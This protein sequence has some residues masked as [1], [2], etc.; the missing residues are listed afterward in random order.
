MLTANDF[1]LIRS[2]LSLMGC[3]YDNLPLA[4]SYYLLCQYLCHDYNVESNTIREALS[5][6]EIDVFQQKLHFSKVFTS[7]DFS[8]LLAFY[9]ILSQLKL[10]INPIAFYDFLWPYLVHDK[11]RFSRLCSNDP[12]RQSIAL[13][14]IILISLQYDTTSIP[15]ELEFEDFTTWYDSIHSFFPDYSSSEELASLFENLWRTCFFT[16]MS[17]PVIASVK[18]RRAIK[19]FLDHC[20]NTGISPEAYLSDY[21][22]IRNEAPGFKNFTVHLSAA[23]DDPHFESYD[24][25]TVQLLVGLRSEPPTFLLHFLHYTDSAGRNLDD[26]EFESSFFVNELM[27]LQ[28]SFTSLLIL[29]PSPSFIRDFCSKGTLRN[30]ATF[31]IDDDLA[32]SLLRTEFPDTLFCTLHQLLEKPQLFDA[33]A[34]FTHL[35]HE[36]PF[37]GIYHMLKE[38][39][40][41]LALI[42][43]TH[44]THKKYIRTLYEHNVHINRLVAIPGDLTRTVPKKKALVYAKKRSN[45]AVPPPVQLFFA[46][47]FPG[48]L[49]YIP[50]AGITFDASVLFQGRTLIQLNNEFARNIHSEKGKIGRASSVYPFSKE[51]RIHYTLMPNRAD[52]YSAQVC[53]RAILNK[54]GK[55]STRGKAL[56][57]RTEKGFRFNTEAEVMSAIEAYPLRSDV[58]H[59]ITMDLWRTH[60]FCKTPYTLKT[61]WYRCLGYLDKD[62]NYKHSVAVSLFCSPNNEAVS[63]LILDQCTDETFQNTL[64]ECTREQLSQ[65]DLI[66]AVAGKNHLIKVNP[67]EKIQTIVDKI[68]E[69]KPALSTVL[70][71]LGKG[72]FT[73]EEESRIVS[74]LLQTDADKGVPRCVVNSQY[75]GVA[76]RLCTG[77]S[78]RE[79]AALQW[80]NIVA[81]DEPD[82]WQFLVMQ[83]INDE[84]KPITNAF[85]NTKRAHRKIPCPEFLRQLLSLRKTYL[86]K[87]FRLSEKRIQNHPIILKDEYPASGLKGF[88]PQ[89]CTARK[90]SAPCKQSLTAAMIPANIINLTERDATF[91]IDLNASLG[92]IFRFNFRLRAK[93]ICA[94]TSGELCYISGIKAKRTY[95][96]HYADYSSTLSQ[97]SIY[98]A[99]NEWTDR[100]LP[101]V[102]VDTP[103][104]YSTVIQA[105]SAD[106]DIYLRLTNMYAMSCFGSFLPEQEEL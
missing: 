7:E 47:S 10:D 29:C 6:R 91:E 18:N 42:P 106:T 55:K 92:D 83:H 82:F 31:L 46:K 8:E 105:T 86:L 67:R 20:K 98:F 30:H 26:F 85:Y 33:V 53:Y 57:S 38:D 89:F 25:K 104:I 28:D 64:S 84:G 54:D 90:L 71:R 43:Q 102:N 50:N 75:L 1:S 24:K 35:A 88:T 95:D 32:C 73:W 87:T 70:S 103:N 16:K 62:I 78:V 39:A 15:N 2:Q 5:S 4:S 68:D 34:V 27:S 65:I 77:M 93:H 41:I 72:A 74:Y 3:D 13:H 21:H 37:D 56:T 48:K 36:L 17:S 51:I 45:T 79:I 61:V 99:L 66:L 19:N 69:K 81:K 97:A 100:Y 94:L 96:E 11:S 12:L 101:F 59:H 80:K 44:L 52:K 63:N 9:Q 14:V 49:I 23:S 22:K 60:Q 40:S 58:Y 76:I